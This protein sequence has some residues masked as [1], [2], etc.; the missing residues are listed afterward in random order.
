MAIV[1]K[2]FYKH[3][4]FD[5]PVVD[6]DS[7]NMLAQKRLH[8]RLQINIL[9]TATIVLLTIALMP[10]EVLCKMGLDPGVETKSKLMSHVKVSS[11]Q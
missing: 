3:V 1:A 9:L 2:E 7:L 4:Y 6:V 11:L 10:A 5:I 8:G